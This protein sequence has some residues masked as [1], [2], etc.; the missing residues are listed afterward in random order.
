MIPSPE[1]LEEEKLVQALNRYDVNRGDFDTQKPTR[2]LATFCSEENIPFL[3]LQP[4]FRRAIN[5]G[6]KCSF[7]IDYHWNSY[8]NNLASVE[9]SRFLLDRGLLPEQAEE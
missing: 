4:A 9:L 7:T 5:A 8:G 1:Q 6:N 3:D 2:L